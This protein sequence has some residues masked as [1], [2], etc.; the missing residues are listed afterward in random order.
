MRGVAVADRGHRFALPPALLQQRRAQQ[1]MGLLG[2][3]AHQGEAPRR[4]ALMLDLA[5]DRLETPGLLTRH[6]A[7]VGAVQHDHGPARVG[8]RGLA[9]LALDRRDRCCRLP[10][11]G[12]ELHGDGMGAQA[13][14]LL[15]RRRGGRQ[16]AQDPG[17]LAE[18]GAHPK[19]GLHP[20]Q[21]RR[22]PGGEQRTDRREH[23]LRIECR[24][25]AAADPNPRCRDLDRAEQGL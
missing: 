10:V 5:A 20:L 8:R 14:A 24:H 13:H 9:G 16:R 23:H 15:V 2:H 19:L 3:A 7:H 11:G 1:R 25:A 22:A 4:A 12:L 17:R 18:R 6:R 21:L